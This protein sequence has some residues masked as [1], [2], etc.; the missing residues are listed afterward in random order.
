MLHVGQVVF[1]LL[2]TA[3]AGE[4]GDD[5][6]QACGETDRPGGQAGRR[7]CFP[8]DFCHCLRRGGQHAAL[9]R[10]HDDH[11]L[12]EFPGNFIAFPGADHR[13]LPVCVVD[14][15]LYKLRLRMLFQD[16]P[17]LRR[18]SM[19]GEAEVPDLSFPH[20]F[21]CKI[22][23]AE[24]FIEACADIAQVVEQIEIKVARAG[25]PE[26]DVELVLCLFC[27]VAVQPCGQLVCEKEAFA[28]IAFH[29]R[30]PDGFFTSRIG[31]GC[32]EIGAAGFQEA[33]HHK[34]RGFNID[35]AV[36]HGETHQAET[37]LQN[38]FTEVCHKISFRGMNRYCFSTIQYTAC[39]RRTA[40]N[41]LHVFR[42]SLKKLSAH[43]CGNIRNKM[44]RAL[45]SR[46]IMKTD[47][48]DRQESA[49]RKT[50]KEEV[51]YDQELRTQRLC[52]KVPRGHDAGV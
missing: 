25:L 44:R 29:Q 43:S 18:R 50:G 17:K 34:F 30:L 45:K 39:G 46:C 7:F 33:V 13:V 47:S 19:E 48:Y 22:P 15:Q 14:L 40:R 26:R 12:V 10:F 8:E 20:L 16:L 35:R 36:L 52:G 41:N 2:L 6:V 28:G 23:D 9:D 3:H 27:R 31:K 38:I 21:F 1:H 37:E 11:R 24:I 42:G 5:A 32:V 49:E 4:D 51:H